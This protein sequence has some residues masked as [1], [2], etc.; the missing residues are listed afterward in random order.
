MR[1]R[2]P[3]SSGG[4]LRRF[5]AASAGLAFGVGAV[6]AVSAILAKQ[7]PLEAAVADAILQPRVNALAVSRVA[8][9]GVEPFAIT[10]ED[11]MADRFAGNLALHNQVSQAAALSARF[12]SVAKKAALSQQKLA[13][14]FGKTAKPLV[15]T[16]HSRPADLRDPAPERFAVHQDQSVPYALAYADPSPMAPAGALA[17]LSVAAPTEI[18]ENLMALNSPLLGDEA[19]D[20]EDTPDV[21]PLPGRRPEFEAATKPGPRALEVE[22]PAK[23]AVEDDDDNKPGKPEKPRTRLS[24]A[25]PDQPKDEKPR[26]GSLFGNWMNGGGSAKARSGV[27]VYD[28]SAAK[29]FMPDGSV[30]EAHSGIGQMADNPRYVQHK[31]KG[32]TPPHVYNLRMRESRFH[33]VEAIRMLPVDGKNKYGRTGLLTH[34]YLLRSGKAESHGCVAFKD[35]NKFLN[36]FK[37][38]KIKQLVVVP[39]GGKA[40]GLKMASNGRGA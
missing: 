19:G 25:K 14:A 22:K 11:V 2:N 37:K 3:K 10:S 21:A 15:R 33:G 35:Y 40:A 13:T 29:V 8:S 20:H 39:G 5:L 28:I 17:A 34:S 36:A 18:E 1:G 7:A 31:M 24:L 30:L 9:L 38:G 4:L 12:D 16:A 26:G 27:A 23:Q 6:W 32:P